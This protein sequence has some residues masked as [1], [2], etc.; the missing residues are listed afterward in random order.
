MT[1]LSR[2]TKLLSDFFS[3]F[4]ITLR[5]M[6]GTR[7]RILMLVLWI[8]SL[9][10]LLVVGDEI[11]QNNEPTENE[12]E[13]PLALSF[14]LLLPMFL[15][16]IALVYTFRE[17]PLLDKKSKQETFIFNICLF[18]IGFGL[19]WLCYVF[20]IVGIYAWLLFRNVSSISIDIRVLPLVVFV[21][22]ILIFITHSI[23]TIILYRWGK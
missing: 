7:F 12:S 2:P 23:T 18:S 11:N 21:P 20:G 6:V 8:L 17:D 10:L 3:D 4:L 14:A 22:F 15:T 16:G 13:N 1:G 5:F 19:F 9:S